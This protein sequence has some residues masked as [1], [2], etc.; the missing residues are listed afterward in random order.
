MDEKNYNCV[1]KILLKQREQIKKFDEMARVELIF[2][3]KFRSTLIS[4]IDSNVGVTEIRFEKSIIL[5]EENN[6]DIR[7]NMD[8]DTINDIAGKGYAYRE[9]LSN[10]NTLVFEKVN[11]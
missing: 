3:K 8:N 7:C 2:E 6:H 10:P 9:D 4:F 11:K 5:E 1:E